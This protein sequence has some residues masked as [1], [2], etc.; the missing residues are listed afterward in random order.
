MYGCGGDTDV[1]IVPPSG[2]IEP[3]DA[4]EIYRTEQA[5]LK[6]E[7]RIKQTAT[8]FLDKRVSDE[9]FTQRLDHLA[10]LLKEDHFQFRFQVTSS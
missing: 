1:W 6:I 7:H 8:L 5:M 9:D 4:G 2:P 10:R 3:K